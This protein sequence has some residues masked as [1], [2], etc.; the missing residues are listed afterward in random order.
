MNRMKIVMDSFGSWLDQ[1]EKIN[2]LK[3]ESFEIVQLGKIKLYLEDE[4]ILKDF[5]ATVEWTNICI[6][7]V[8]GKE[9]V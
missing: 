8:T 3:H 7:A 1:G 2:K 5:W 4:D 6:T 9:K